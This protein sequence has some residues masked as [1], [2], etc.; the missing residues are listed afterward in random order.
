[1]ALIRRIS[2]R[3][4]RSIPVALRARFESDQ[5]TR[6]DPETWDAE[7][8]TGAWTRLGSL[9]EMSRYGVITGYCRQAGAAASV[10]DIGCGSGLL[11]GWLCE[12]DERRYLGIDLSPVAIA[13]ARDLVGGRARFAVADAAGFDPG[14]P[15]DIII[16]NEMLYYLEEP[17][18]VLARYARVLGPGGVFIISMWRAP[19]S[20]RTW[21]RCAP[22]LV[23]QDEVRLHHA[24][25]GIKWTVWLCR[26]SGPARG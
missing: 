7:Y 6:I 9:T 1:M 23:V 25:S 22:H 26:P 11:A 14:E 19:D 24:A 21:R 17:E 18:A 12:G 2:G 4:R 20:L 15:F 5:Q 8:E 3:L 16:F 10:L 13:Q